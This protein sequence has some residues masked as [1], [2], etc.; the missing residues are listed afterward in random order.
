MWKEE[1]RTMRPLFSLLPELQIESI[2]DCSCGLGFKT[3]LFAKQGYEVEGSDASAIAIRF[4]PKLAKEE[5]VD[6]R[7]FKSRYDELDKRCKRRY[8]C[9][10]SDNFDEI[11][12][13]GDLARSAKGIYSVI[14][15]RG[16]FI[17][18]GAPP[19]W[20][21]TDLMKQ[22]EKAWKRHKKFIILPPYEKGGTRVTSIEVNERNPEGILGDR[23]FLIEEKGKT[24]AEIAFIMSPRIKW[25]FQD[26]HEVLRKAGFSEVNSARERLIVAVK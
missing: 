21:R 20:S 17:F 2:L 6:V 25:T 14:K 11:R 1:K 22:I 23:I 12:M 13:R 18:N 3:I 5:G 9:V 19:Q 4:A 24:R 16:K 10:Y 8:D 15:E 26:Y 7:F